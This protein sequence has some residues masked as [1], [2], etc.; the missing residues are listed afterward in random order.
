[1]VSLSRIYIHPVKSM[2][3]VQVSH[4]LVN[5]EG[6]ANDRAF[7]LTET[8]G[9][10]IT[11]RQHPQLVLF[12]P[13]ILQNGLHLS[14]PDGESVMVSLSDFSATAA[15]TEVWGNH[16][17]AYIAP[18][19]INNWL[20]GYFGRAVQ[21]RWTGQRP[22]R[23][24]KRLPAIPLTFADG[25]PFLLISEASF[26]DLQRRCGAG[27]TLTQFRPNIVVSG[28]EP[29]AEDSWKTLRIGSVVFEAVKPCSRCIFTTINVE[30]GHKHPSVEP[31]STLQGFRTAANGD[32][33]F[34][35]NLIAHSS[36]IIRAG[37]KVEILE[38][39][40]PRRYHQVQVSPP[41]PVSRA[42]E[43]AL[44]IDYQGRIFT[45]NNQH[46]LLEQLEM[47]GIKLPYSCRAGICGSC[48]VQLVAG[49]VLPLTASAVA[50][51]GKILAC[52]CIPKGDIRIG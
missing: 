26:L 50:G 41:P 35:Q 16:F 42:A 51:N 40:T 43:K 27:I 13:V 20:S 30:S 44:A 47:Q 37:D 34:G 19:A 28:T 2:R 11:A 22:D 31:L 7:M 9:T 39:Q 4:A 10:F 52:S 49:E 48:K 15:P 14:A 45:G 1:M 38:T 23:R 21:L 17:T 5:A 24:V 3:G 29:F 33:D 46:I 18:E 36:G 6:L 32:V 8:D 25:Y 12:T